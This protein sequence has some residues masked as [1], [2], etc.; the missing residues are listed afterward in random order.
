MVRFQ[1]WIELSD[2]WS[3]WVKPANDFS[4]PFT[5][6]EHTLIRV[7]T[8]LK[9]R[10][11]CLTRYRIRQ[12]LSADSAKQARIH[13]MNQWLT[14]SKPYDSIIISDT[15][16]SMHSVS[17]QQHPQEELLKH[18]EKWCTVSHIQQHMWLI[19]PEVVLPAHPYSTNPFQLNSIYW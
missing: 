9:F 13:C 12:C 5:L 14:H 3:K 8:I 17:L 10:H 16:N 6:P 4:K 11:L 19:R 1:V 7:W 2:L 15:N 18:P